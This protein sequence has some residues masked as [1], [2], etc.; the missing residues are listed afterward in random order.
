LIIFSSA[1][2]VPFH[3][4]LFPGC[5]YFFVQI[6]GSPSYLPHPT[7]K[8]RKINWLSISG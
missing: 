2:S 3:V 7:V 6:D 4:I 8:F 5:P 1:I